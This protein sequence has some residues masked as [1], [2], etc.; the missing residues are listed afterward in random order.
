MSKKPEKHDSDDESEGEEDVAM[1]AAA[2]PQAAKPE[3]KD[4]K[5]SK[6]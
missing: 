6:E 1:P 2:A 5:E 3:V 4:T